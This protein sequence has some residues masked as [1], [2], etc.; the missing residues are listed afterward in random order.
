[1]LCDVFNQFRFVHKEPLTQIYSDHD[2]QKI[3]PVL[4][5]AARRK[6]TWEKHNFVATT[7][8]AI[9]TMDLHGVNRTNYF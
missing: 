1:M 3:S 7:A 4:Q 5:S 2:I 9:K 8:W 6:Q